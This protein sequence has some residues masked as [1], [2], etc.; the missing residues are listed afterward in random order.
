[1]ILICFQKTR[2]VQSMVENITQFL[3]RLHAV[4]V[5]PG[6]GRHPIVMKAVSLLIQKIIQ[7]DLP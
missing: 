5:G 6:L 4:V 1:M 3:P 7:A 2:L